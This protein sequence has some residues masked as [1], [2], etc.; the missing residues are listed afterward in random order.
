MCA[1]QFVNVKLAAECKYMLSVAGFNNN[2]QQW[3]DIGNIGINIKNWFEH[4]EGALIYLWDMFII[5]A[6]NWP[7]SDSIKHFT[8]PS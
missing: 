8:S 1:P 5:I 3:L 4:K 2:A 6:I 7:L